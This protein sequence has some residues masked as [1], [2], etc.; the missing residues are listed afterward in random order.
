MFVRRM[1]DNDL[2]LNVFRDGHHYKKM[3]L[4][5]YPTMQEATDLLVIKLEGELNYIT[6]E[7]YISDMSKITTPATIILGFGHTATMDF[8]AH[9]EI[10]RI[11]ALRHKHNIQVYIT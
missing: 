5:T 10:E 2:M 4:A 3:P 6:I 8:D 9:E 1:I 11:I 7:S